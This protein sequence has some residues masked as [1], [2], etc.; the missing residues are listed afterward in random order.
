MEENETQNEVI[1]D[2]AKI[3]KEENIITLGGN[4]YIRIQNSLIKCNTINRMQIKKS[5]NGFV[6]SIMF[7]DDTERTI[8]IS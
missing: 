2:I 6:C 3:V 7:T 4:E 8:A 1:P 5:D